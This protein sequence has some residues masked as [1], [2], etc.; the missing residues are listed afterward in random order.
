[1]PFCAHAR[2]K[3]TRA[4]LRNFLVDAVSGS[5]EHLHD[6]LEGKP[7][8]NVLTCAKSFAE[9]GARQGLDREA[10][11]LGVVSSDVVFLG[12]VDEV[13]GR[14]ALDAELGRLRLGEVLSFVRTVEVFA[15]QGRLGASH[16]AAND[17]VRAAVVFAD[18]HVVNGFAWAGHVHGVRQVVPHGAR[19]LGL[20][21]EHFV[22]LVPHSAVNVVGLGRAASRVHHHHAALA[23]VLGVERAGEELVVG[24]VHGVAALERD[25][26]LV[27]RQLRADLLWGLARELAHG[28]VEA[29]EGA[30]HVV[31]AALEGHHEGAGVLERRGAVALLALQWLL[32]QVLALYHHGRHGQVALLEEHLVSRHERFVVGVKHHRQREE[33]ATGEFHVLDHRKVGL[34]VHEAGQWR[35]TTVADKLH[36]AHLPLVQLHFLVAGLGLSVRVHPSEEVNEDAAMGLLE[37][38]ERRRASQ[39]LRVVRCREGNR[40]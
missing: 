12:G 14:H 19:V 32:R 20:G 26:V 33:E 16:V 3:R 31:L 15:V 13:Q 5:A 8:R 1:M 36:V 6:G 40:R 35:E 18:H 2:R 25:H 21:L 28:L 24:A 29:L 27:G 37:H 7:L 38:L 17:E 9:F 4:L 30:R 10:L 23:H 11:F 34:F 39:G 22:S